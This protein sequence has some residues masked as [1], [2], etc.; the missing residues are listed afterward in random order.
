[1]GS[2]QLRG[3][4]HVSCIGRWIFYPWA[5]GTRGGIFFKCFWEQGAV[6]HLDLWRLYYP[7]RAECIGTRKQWFLGVWPRGTK[8]NFFPPLG[9]SFCVEWE[10][11]SMLETFVEIQVL[12]QKLE[13]SCLTWL[14]TRPVAQ[15]TSLRVE[16]VFRGPFPNPSALCACPQPR[17]QGGCML[18]KTSGHLPAAFAS[19]SKPNTQGVPLNT[20]CQFALL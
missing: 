7:W 5:A 19:C 18:L 16:G 6:Q 17:V 3:W 14:W 1:M 2:S 8:L 9:W 20:C 15:V 13:D 10:L 11:Y 12:E 4:T